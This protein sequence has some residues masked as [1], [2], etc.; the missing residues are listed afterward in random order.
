MVAANDN[1]GSAGNGSSVVFA[2][3]AGTEYQIAVDGL[4]G[5]S[6]AV[7][8]RWG[9]PAAV[10]ADVPMLP[11][12]GVALLGLACVVVAA[13]MHAGRGPRG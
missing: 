10:S 6:G 9:P 12:W 3:R 5:A 8:L 4:G 11:A 2:A 13:R 7:V 1:D